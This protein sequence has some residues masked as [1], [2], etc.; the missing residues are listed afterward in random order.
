MACGARTGG[1]VARRPMPHSRDQMSGNG[2]PVSKSVSS[3]LPIKPE[4]QLVGFW[5]CVYAQI[6]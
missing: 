2:K 1:L 3:D 6:R 5:G 4:P